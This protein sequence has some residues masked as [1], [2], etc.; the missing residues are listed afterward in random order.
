MYSDRQ[1]KQCIN[2][3]QDVDAVYHLPAR[4]EQR[5]Q[6]AQ[7]DAARSWRALSGGAG[8]GHTFWK[9][10]EGARILI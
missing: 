6:R 9:S 2:K 4:R 5:G 7:R 8:E 10:V 1:L 3:Y